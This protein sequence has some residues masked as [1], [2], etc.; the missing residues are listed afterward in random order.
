MARTRYKAAM[1]TIPLKDLPAAALRAV[2][3]E[4]YTASDLK[5]DVLAGVIVGI[6]ALPLAM[7]LAIG[8]GVA[9]QHGLYTA[10]VAGFVVAALGGSRTQVSGPTA[11]FIVILAPI[12]ARF[13]M[14][15]LLTSGLLAGVILVAMGLARMGRFIQFVPY[16]V[17]NGFT[18][19]IATVIAT[20]QLKDLFGLALPRNPEHF[21]DKVVAMF[22]ARK[23]ASGWEVAIGVST[24]AILVYLPRITRRIPA[25]LVALPASGGASPRG[26]VIEN[27]DGSRV[28][29]GPR[30]HHALAGPE[31]PRRNHGVD[32]RDRNGLVHS[33]LVWRR[34]G[35]RRASLPRSRACPRP[36]SSRVR[37]RERP[38][39]PRP[40]GA[41]ARSALRSS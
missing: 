41:G 6:V 38:S 19:G 1:G 14:A 33:D 34:A 2:M 31:I 37:S 25:P 22:E 30:R 4:G 35:A 27:R 8:V 16:P 24:L 5:S 7:A 13:G 12:Y 17:T 40:A 26:A 15:G 9:P 32:G 20:L 3:R 21:L 18:A 11:A 23:S 10:I 39:P 36:P 29:R 28:G